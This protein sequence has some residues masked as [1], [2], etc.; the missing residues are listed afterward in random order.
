MGFWGEVCGS[1]KEKSWVRHWL[2]DGFRT[3]GADDQ[4][5]RRWLVR[6]RK[7][8]WGGGPRKEVEPRG[9]GAG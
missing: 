1:L 8:L 2:I 6:S 9:V 3:A 7:V 5:G 4:W